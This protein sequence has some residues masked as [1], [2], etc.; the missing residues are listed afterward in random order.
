[1]PPT[2]ADVDECAVGVH[3]CQQNAN[4]TNTIGSFTCQCRSGYS[5]D[6]R[7]TQCVDVDECQQAHTGTGTGGGGGGTDTTALC[8]VNALCNNMPGSYFCSCE[9]GADCFCFKLFL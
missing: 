6:G 1:M 8:P 9:A 2:P 3:D 4:C 7:V 5:G